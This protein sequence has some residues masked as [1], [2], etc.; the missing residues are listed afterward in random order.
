MK[1]KNNIYVGRHGRIFITDP[2]TKE[3]RIFNYKSSDWKNPYLFKN[4]DTTKEC[5]DMYRDH[6]VKTK[7]IDRVSE[8]KGKCLG[9]FCK[10]IPGEVNC[11]AQVLCE[12]AEMS[13]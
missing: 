5:L 3:K 1:N 8:L 11:H 12:L 4:F 10:Q 9:C 2:I 13:T 6:L 7:L